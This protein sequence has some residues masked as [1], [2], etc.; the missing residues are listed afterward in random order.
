MPLPSLI[1]G[2]SSNEPNFTAALEN[3]DEYI[4]FA[5]YGDRGEDLGHAIGRIR[6]LFEKDSEGA[7]LRLT[8]LG[9][10]DEYYQWY[11]KQEGK[12]DGLPVD[13]YHHLC[14]R[15]VTRCSRGCGGF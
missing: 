5:V 15:H 9:C 11:I 1:D 4:C 8:Y 12:R 14:R 2:S 13:C 3:L 7:Y 6:Q 10:S